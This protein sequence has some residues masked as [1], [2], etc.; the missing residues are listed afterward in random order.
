MY[1]FALVLTTIYV[2]SLLIE[3]A[4]NFIRYNHSN[5]LFVIVG[6]LKT[7]ARENEEIAERLKNMGFDAQYL[8]IEFQKNWLRT[9][10]PKLEHIMPY[11]S[12]NRRNI[13]YLYAAQ[14]GAK[15]IIVLDDDNHVG[16]EDYLAEHSVVGKTVTVNSA[17]SSNG[18]FNPCDILKFNVNHRIYMRGL[19]FHARESDI[20]DLKIMTEHGRVVIN[21]G[22]WKMTP[23]VDAVTHL[24]FPNLQSLSLKMKRIALGSNIYAPINT[25][26]TA[27][28]TEILPCFYFI[29]MDKGMDWF[30]DV[31]AG[32]F[33]RKVIDHMG[34]KVT[35]GSPLSIHKRRKRNEVIQLAKQI[36]GMLLHEELSRIVPKIELSGKT[37]SESYYDL[38]EKLSK[39]RYQH[40]FT[41]YMRKVTDA[42]KIWVESCWSVGL[43]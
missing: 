36:S 21:V 8:D 40:G 1:E 43:R 37:Y 39:F 15:T 9:Y 33:A 29:P 13:G 4:D 42:M 10:A 5:V 2:P 28:L 16:Q 31:W 38:A 6:D 18:W 17:Y 23:D 25:Q 41:S 7:P 14:M 34:D 3:Y 22:L 27:F 20:S 12:D 30:G 26:N 35:F 19:P 11:N 24:I 32:L